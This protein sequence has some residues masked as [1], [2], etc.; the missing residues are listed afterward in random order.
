MPLVKQELL[1]FPEH[2]NSPPIFSG[3]RVAQFL[4]FG[5]VLCRSLFVLLPIVLSVHRFTGFDYPF[6]IFKLFLLAK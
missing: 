4:I 2:L 1:T 6:D 5:A 3:V